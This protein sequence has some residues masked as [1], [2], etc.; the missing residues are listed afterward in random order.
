MNPAGH[1]GRLQ[2]A[3]GLT[4][5]WQISGRKDLN[6]QRMVELDLAYVQSWS[7]GGDLVILIKTF[8]VVLRR[9]GAY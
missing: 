6:Y 7:L 5:P 9:K 3:P 4:G 1:H 8:F 2:V